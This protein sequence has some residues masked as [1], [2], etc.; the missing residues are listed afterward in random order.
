MALDAVM[1]L[2][3]NE[4]TVPSVQTLKQH[5]Y[6]L[7]VVDGSPDAPC[8]A[9]ADVCGKFDFRDI[10]SGIELA[11]KENIKAVVPTHD[12]AVVPA[13]AISKALGLNGPTLEAAKTATNKQRMREQWLKASLPTPDYKIASTFDE[14]KEAVTVSGYPAICKPTDDVGG[15]SRGVMKI[16]ENSN[17]AEAYRFAISF[18]DSDEVIVEQF[19]DGLEHSA[20]VL[21]RD[22]EGVV[23]MVSDKVKT[24]PPYR[25][26]LSVVYPTRQNGAQLDSLRSLAVSAAKAVGLTDGVA[27]VE[28][29]S[30]PDGS[31]VLFEL[32]LRCGGGVT[33][34]PI[35]ALV[36][37][38]N[39][40]VEYVE[41]LLGNKTRAITPRS[42]SA[43]SYQF[44]TA[45]PGILNKLSGLEESARLPGIRSACITVEPGD[46][47]QPLKTSAQRLGYFIAVGRTNE[48][49]LR[50][51]LKALNNLRFEYE[52]TTQR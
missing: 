25:V 41:I 30:L 1:I 34:H 48:Q 52:E 20:E 51:G 29:C 39:Q 8:F 33:A 3:G 15:G 18:S 50:H 16:D 6:L 37:G 4:H 11:R 17:L 7:T 31:Q 40:M 13:A 22:G 9:M 43:A 28:L 32:G 44:I 26:D 42:K 21:M 10:D 27:H 47:I 23:L 14:F 38:V 5:G 46:T 45:A 19:Y 49:A 35:C 36:T 24:A 2:G 12:R